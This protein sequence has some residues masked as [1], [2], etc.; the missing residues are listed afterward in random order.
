MIRCLPSALSM[1]SA[2]VVLSEG[3]V[4]EQRVEHRLGDH[5]LRQHV[6]GVVAA[7][8]VVE[9]AAQTLQELVEGFHDVEGRISEQRFDA[10]GVPLRDAC[11]VLGPVFPG[12]GEGDGASHRA[13]V[14]AEAACSARSG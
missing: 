8:A 13:V 1:P 3:V 10:R 4:L 12:P 14:V 6:D 2:R 9:V 11:D 5:V 7:D